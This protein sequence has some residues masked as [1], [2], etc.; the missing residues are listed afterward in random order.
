MQPVLPAFL[1]DKLRDQPE[2]K[3]SIDEAF[4]LHYHN[5]IKRLFTLMHSPHPAEKHGAKDHV[6]FQFENLKHALAKLRLKNGKPMTVFIEALNGYLCHFSD[7]HRGI[8][9]SDSTLSLLGELDNAR[10]LSF[11]VGT[12][13]P[14]AGK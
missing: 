5:E 2:T 6:G 9:F 3:A 14:R 7:S 4:C 1:S 13:Y 8:E 10:L 12:L 11:D